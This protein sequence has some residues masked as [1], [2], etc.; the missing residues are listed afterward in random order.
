V[1]LDCKE[2]DQYGKTASFEEVLENLEQ[3]RQHMEKESLETRRL[4]CARPKKMQ[5][6]LEEYRKQVAEERERAKVLPG[7]RPTESLKE[8]RDAAEKV[9]DELVRYA[10]Q[11]GQ[12]RQLAGGKRGAGPT[13]TADQRDGRR[14]WRPDGRHSAAPSPSSRPHPGGGPGNV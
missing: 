12:G 9:F 11:G 3:T 8:A 4:C 7:V 10:P 14:P 6:N 2:A 1:I 5:K 13:S